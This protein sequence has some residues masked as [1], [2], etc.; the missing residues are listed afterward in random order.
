M[1]NVFLWVLNTSLSA[2]WVVLAVLLARLLMKKAPKWLGSVLWALVALRLLCPIS[3]ESMLSLVPSS[4]PIP[5]DTAFSDTPLV[6]TGLPPVDAVVNPILSETL[7]P[8]VGDSV[9]PSQVLLFAAAVLWVA[10]M[11]VMG[12]YTLVTTLRL[13]RQVRES[14]SLRDN[15]RL[16]D[17]LSTP[18]ILGVFRPRIYLPSHLTEEQME[19]VIAHEQAHLR[20]RDH[21]WK[22]LGYLL[23]AVHWFNPLLWVA[24][25]LLCRDIESAC[26]ERVVRDMEREERLLYSETLLACSM[27]RRLV[28]ACPLAFG[29]NG[30]K[31]RIKAVLYYKKPALWILIAGVVTIAVVAVCFLTNP[32]ADEPTDAPPVSD[33][34]TTTTEPTTT[35][36]TTEKPTTTTTTSTPFPGMSTREEHPTTAPNRAP[37]AAGVVN[38][39]DWTEILIIGVGDA[40]QTFYEDG[41][42]EYQFNTWKKEYVLVHYADGGEKTVDAALAD[43]D[44]TLKDLD[45]YGIAYRKRPKETTT[46]TTKES[47]T[48]TTEKPT[49]TTTAAPTTTTTAPTTTTTA[50]TA[51]TTTKAAS[52]IPVINVPMEELSEKTYCTTPVDANFEEG[53]L[54]I[55]LARSVSAINHLYTA[56]EF[57]DMFGI[58]IVSVEA[59]IHIDKENSNALVNWDRYKQIFKLIL[60]N[61]SKQAVLDAIKIIEQHPYVSSASPNMIVEQEL[62]SD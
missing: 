34:T 61:K 56:E 36:T 13:R 28:T 35:T 43:G 19:Y 47:T 2:C 10:G 40:F 1:E 31:Q 4:Q 18:F 14:V 55:S 49:A 12:V 41:D 9:N 3:I 38:I 39:V 15:I 46:T 42:Y 58:E 52:T 27:P 45:S 26:D 7:T 37:N 23:L 50:T 21:W 24:Y 48:T 8:S 11:L 62:W 59:L 5:S 51:T 16:C 44:I 32:P 17:N 60:P 57:S 33:T 25:I 29:E 30:V 54:L 6:D 20:R 53:T 22:P